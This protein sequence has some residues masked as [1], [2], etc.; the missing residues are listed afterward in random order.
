M[1][2]DTESLN[3][4]QQLWLDVIAIGSFTI[5]LCHNFQNY[6]AATTAFASA[7]LLTI[8]VLVLG[9]QIVKEKKK[10]EMWSSHLFIPFSGKTVAAKSNEEVQSKTRIKPGKLCKQ[11]PSY[12]CRQWPV[13]PHAPWLSRCS[14]ARGSRRRG[15]QQSRSQCTPWCELKIDKARKQRRKKLLSPSSQA[16]AE[17]WRL[18]QAGGRCQQCQKWQRQRGGQR[19]ELQRRE[20]SQVFPNNPPQRQQYLRGHQKSIMTVGVKKQRL[21]EKMAIILPTGQWYAP[22]AGINDAWYCM[23]LHGIAWY[24][25]VLYGIAWYFWYSIVVFVVSK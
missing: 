17:C 13:R 25:M 22:S 19:R 6:S 8:S 9:Y 2:W 3:S 20:P 12:F 18:Q 10:R 11:C 14:S 15:R 21:S 24:C 5:N 23:V 4:S 16:S 7:Q 1:N